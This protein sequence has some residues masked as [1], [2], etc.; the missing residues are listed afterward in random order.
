[1]SNWGKKL[2]LWTP[3]IDSKFTSGYVKTVLNT[4]IECQKQG[5]GFAWGSIPN[6]SILP[7]ARNRAVVEFM[8]R[9]ATHFMFLDSDVSVDSKDVMACILSDLEFTAIPYSRRHFDKAMALSI[10][11]NNPNITEN[12]VLSSISGAAFQLNNLESKKIDK[13]AKEFNLVPCSRVGAGAMILK[14]SVFEKMSSIVDEYIDKTDESQKE[15]K[16]KNYFGYSKKD[17]L[18]IGEDWTFCDQ[19]NSLG[20]TIYLKI[21]ANSAHEGTVNYEYNF[22]ELNK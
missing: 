21:D 6:T 1:M 19:W 3:S 18:F 5:I 2:E 9:N 15:I 14:R 17:G 20:E 12:G 22:Y 7:V 8:S 16:T 4:Q 13:R 11:R 10:I